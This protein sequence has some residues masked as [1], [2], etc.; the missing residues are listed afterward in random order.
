MLQGR[1]DLLPIL[2]LLFLAFLFELAHLLRRFRDCLR[3]VSCEQLLSVGLDF[4]SVHDGY[5]KCYA[6]PRLF[7]I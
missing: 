6:P 3:A 7:P 5:T 2:S 1:L 4:N